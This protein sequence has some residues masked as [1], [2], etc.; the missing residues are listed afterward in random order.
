MNLVLEGETRLRLE[1]TGD[2][3]EI[4]SEGVALSPYHLL[5]ASLASC[6]A[7]AVAS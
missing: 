1:M 4:A 3:F 6:T 5:V 2:A 7:L